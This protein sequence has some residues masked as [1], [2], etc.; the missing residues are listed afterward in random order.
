MHAAPARD[1]RYATRNISKHYEIKQIQDTIAVQFVPGMRVPR[2]AGGG[3][4]GEEEEEE[5][6]EAEAETRGEGRRKGG[7]GGGGR[8]GG[9]CEQEYWQD[10]LVQP[11]DWY[12]HPP[13][14]PCCRNAA[15]LVLTYTFA[16][17]LA[18]A[19]TTMWSRH[20]LC[21]GWCRGMSAPYERT[22]S[23]LSMPCN[24]GVSDRF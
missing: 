19:D 20:I 16:R 2:G 24:S 15:A 3:E 12:N 11:P 7:G 14:T 17:L 13:H 9:S 8:V 22:R 4:G 23:G 21:D 6:G 5:G 10:L 18:S 1:R